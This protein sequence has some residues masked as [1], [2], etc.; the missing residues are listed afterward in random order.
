MQFRL[1]ILVAALPLVAACQTTT[2][3][4][5][6]TEL[7]GAA[8]LQNRDGSPAGRAMLYRDPVEMTISVTLSG[9]EPGTR[10]VH[11]HAVGDCSASDFTSA[12]GHL[13]PQDN[14][15]G[16]ENPRGTHLGDLP[17]VTVGPNGV[18]SVSDV[19]RGDPVQVTGWIFDADGTAVVV[20]EDADD[21]LS[22]PAGNAGERVACGVLS[23]T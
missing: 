6:P 22:D 13:N 2:V 14:E 16:S 15:H 3:D 18:G 4:E 12:S 23:P 8:D 21:Y 17:N 20:H 11:L 19:L 7:V 1:P 10:A 5:L 9:V